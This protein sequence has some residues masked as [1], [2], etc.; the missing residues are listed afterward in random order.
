MVNELSWQIPETCRTLDEGDVH[1]FT[2][3][4]NPPAEVRESL[5]TYLS[6]EESARA[7]RFRFERDR[8]RFVVGRGVLRS[9]LGEYVE[10]PPEKIQF[11]Y[12]AQGKPMLRP[13]MSNGRLHFNLAHSEDI[14]VLGITR[15]GQVGVDVERVRPL[16]D[17][18][19]LVKQFFSPRESEEFLK[20]SEV[21]KPEAFFNLWT[22]KE[23]WLKATGEGIAHSLHL[24]EVSFL[25]GQS[26]RLLS[27]P[28]RLRANPDWLLHPLYPAR[29]FA[30]AVAVNAKQAQFKCWP[31]PEPAEFNL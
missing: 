7:A 6:E 10:A 28:A 24:V 22:R 17:F 9:V 1:V 29:D 13:E 25:P 19:E 20:L 3:R 14:A 23:A 5:A 8:H 26:A 11:H 27:I 12:N 4:L 2:F 31:L 18:D 15:A 21:E 30:A 16:P